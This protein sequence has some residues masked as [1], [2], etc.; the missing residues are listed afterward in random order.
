MENNYP[1][2]MTMSDYRHCEGY[3]RKEER[4]CEDCEYYIYDIEK[5]DFECT[6]YEKDIA[7]DEDASECEHF[8][9]K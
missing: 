9:Q 6:Y 4:L 3:G 8:T 5:D 1:D 7:E 2:G